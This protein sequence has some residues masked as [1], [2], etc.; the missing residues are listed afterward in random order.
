M[1]IVPSY[2]S[3]LAQSQNLQFLIDTSQQNLEMKSVWRQ[4]LNLGV[5]QMSLNF[6]A[7]IGRDRIEAA[8]SIVDS[9]APA[10]LR[11]R[12]KLE[13]YKGKIPAIKEKFRM[14][15][16]D[17]RAI[18][19]L[20]ALPLNGSNSNDSLIQFLNK[21]LQEAAVSGDKRIDIMLLQA[22]STLLIDVN[23]TNNPDGVAYGVIDLLAQSYQSQGVP[24]VWTDVVNATPIDD[25]EKY[26][27]INWLTRGRQFGKILMPYELWFNFKRSTQ[28]KNY[29][30]TFYNTGK[31]NGGAFAVTLNSINEM[32][33]A[34]MWPQIEIVNHVANVE[35]DGKATFIRPF[36]PTNIA[37]VP[38]GKLGTLFNAISMEKVHPV[39]DKNY[40]DF[41]PTL[42]SKWA[43][44][45]PLVEFTAME[46]NA[47]PGVN[48]DGIFILKT[49]TVTASFV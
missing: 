28:V 6:D 21:D 7:A 4:Y 37:F 49:A 9:D 17:M 41:G 27:Q 5:P 3:D 23:I 35:V 32:F 20:R 33:G 36:F 43:E 16:D 24:I 13:L 10:P 39:T 46:M 31:A 1:A 19:V 45:D 14:N 15:Q 12:N 22:I 48:V 47:F 40:A 44:S 29:L 38:N 34:N 42:V 30:S 2:F 8:A 11:S 25:I 26:L 18:E